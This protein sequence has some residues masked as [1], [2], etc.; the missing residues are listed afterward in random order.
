[1]DPNIVW[2]VLAGVLM[3]SALFALNR[4]ERR[5]RERR[6]LARLATLGVVV[7]G[8]VWWSKYKKAQRDRL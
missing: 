7:G 1:M 6:R 5:Y 8:L 4:S 2:L 3:W